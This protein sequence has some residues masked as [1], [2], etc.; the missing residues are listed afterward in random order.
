MDDSYKWVTYRKLSRNHG[1]IK[2]IYKK[3]I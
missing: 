3:N 1:Y 2:W